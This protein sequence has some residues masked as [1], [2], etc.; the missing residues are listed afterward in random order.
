[1]NTLLKNVLHEHLLPS[2]EEPLNPKSMYTLS[3]A[4]G[5]PDIEQYQYHA[6]PNDCYVYLKGDDDNRDCCPKCKAARYITF[7]KPDGSEGR[8]PTKVT[9]DFHIEKQIAKFHRDKAWLARKGTHRDT[10][11]NGFWG[12][13][14]CKRMDRLT[15]G[16]FSNKRNGVYDMCGDGVEL[17]TTKAHSCTI[18]S[19]R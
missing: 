11:L 4:L 15:K 17:L 3:Q 5:V 9:Y 2:D 18:F 19:I 16:E 6:C 10:S 12:S 1:M 8:R 7:S 13:E 14:E